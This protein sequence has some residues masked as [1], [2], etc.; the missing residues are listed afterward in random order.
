MGIWQQGMTLKSIERD[1][2]IDA[3][4]F[5]DCNKE[6][7]ARALGISTKGLYNKIEAYKKEDEKVA[8][9]RQK[10]EEKYQEEMSDFRGSFN[11][12]LVD[13][14]I[15][16]QELDPDESKMMPMENNIAKNY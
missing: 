11:E 3:Y 12:I 4:R 10:R 2:I 1:V 6:A 9:A 7:T 15:V 14:G 5:F 16:P 13:E 8:A